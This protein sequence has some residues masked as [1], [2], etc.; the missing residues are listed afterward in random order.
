MQIGAL[1]Y[2]KL[3]LGRIRSRIKNPPGPNGGVQLDGLELLQEGK[4]EL[5]EWR[6]MLIY[7]FGGLLPITMG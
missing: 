7:R 1:A 6:E 3:M 5:K 4:D 2:A